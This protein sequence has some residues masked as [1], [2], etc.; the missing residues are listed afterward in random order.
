M[1]A[2]FKPKRKTQLAED[3]EVRAIITLFHFEEKTRAS[4]KNSKT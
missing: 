1:T 2:L 3:G 4:S